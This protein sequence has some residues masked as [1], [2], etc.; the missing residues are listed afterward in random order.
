[1]I[2]T[3]QELEMLPSWHEFIR[4]YSLTEEQKLQFVQYMQMVQAS[5]ELFNLTAITQPQQII[6]YHFQDSLAISNYYDMGAVAMLADVGTGAGFPSIPLKIIFPH[7]K[8]VLIEVA[9]KKIMFLADVVD[10]L[11]LKDV[12]I[13]DLDWRT[14]LRKT[15]ASIDLFVSR[16]SLHTD[17]LMRMFKPS[18]PYRSKVLAY[19]ASKEWLPTKVEAPFLRN[20]F[21]YTI[22]NKK[23]RIILFA[24]LEP[25]KFSQ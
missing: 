17:E 18:C 15:D 11:N 22:K 3:P 25:H 21:E 16:A 20:E 14:F 19:W 13:A 10:R 6:A 2:A 24:S 5:N 4:E 8:I 23:R 1:M 7:L 12:E 9:H